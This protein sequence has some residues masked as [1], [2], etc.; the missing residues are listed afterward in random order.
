MH[1]SINQIPSHTFVRSRVHSN[2]AAPLASFSFAQG[3]L[4]LLEK[5]MILEAQKTVFLIHRMF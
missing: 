3:A 5:R 4:A 2:L 1:A